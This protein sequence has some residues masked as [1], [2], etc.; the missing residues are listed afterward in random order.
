MAFFKARYVKKGT[1][2]HKRA[3]ATIRYITHRPGKDKENI[4]RQLFGHDGALEKDDAYAAIDQAPKGTY[5][6]RMIINPDP[7]KEDTRRDLYL[8]GVTKQTILRLEERLDLVGKIQF[9]AAVHN[10]HSPLRHVH[11]LVLVPGKLTKDVI[12]ELHQAATDAAIR[13]RQQL[14][15]V[16]EAKQQ[17]AARYFIHSKADFV[18]STPP[19]NIMACAD[20][21][22]I[23][24]AQVLS[25]I[26]YRC[27][28]CGH[29]QSRYPYTGA[30]RREVGWQQS[31]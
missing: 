20:C 16:L 1:E 23:Q 29:I 31:L 4:F 7:K 21:G 13:Q 3:K 19:P 12:A 30:T 17:Q 9:F 5:F 22:T 26:L 8:Q 27:T 2:E 15:Q 24:P 18:Q 10:D 25:R 11:L 28:G 6:Y 14:D